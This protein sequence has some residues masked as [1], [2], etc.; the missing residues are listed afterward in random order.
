MGLYPEIHRDLL[1]TG[2]LLHDIGKLEEYSWDLDITF[3]DKG[4]LAG[5]ITLAVEK[6]AEAI[7]TIPDFPEDLALHI[8]HLILAHHGRYEYGS[9]RRPKTLEAIALHH[10]ENLDAQV[11]R[12]N[13]LITEARNSGRAWTKYDRE[14][15]RS[16]Y[17]HKE[18]A[19][20]GVD[21]GSSIDSP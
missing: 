9:P 13:Y 21:E 5:H 12:F 1:I 16:L 10:L 2:I 7:S 14:L 8:R 17:A 4:R 19:R 6:V 15:G 11:N 20:M 18:A 3:T